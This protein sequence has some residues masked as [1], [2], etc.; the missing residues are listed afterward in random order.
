MHLGVSARAH[1]AWLDRIY[2]LLSISIPESI[3]QSISQP[4]QRI[5][6]RSENRIQTGTIPVLVPLPVLYRTAVLYSGTVPALDRRFS[7]E[8]RVLTEFHAYP[9]NRF[10]CKTR[11]GRPLV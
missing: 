10:I 7:A 3:M 11:T 4:D 1:G 9:E 8:I 2:D 5:A 6:A